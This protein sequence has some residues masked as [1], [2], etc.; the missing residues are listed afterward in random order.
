M[1]NNINPE[2]N[3]ELHFVNKHKHNW[4]VIFD[5]GCRNDSLFKNLECEVHYFEPELNFLNQLEKQLTNNKISKYNNF[6]LS[7][8]EGDFTYYERFQSFLNRKKTFPTINGT[9]K[10][11]SLKK[12]VNYLSD[13][14]IKNIDF[15]KID[16]EG[17]ELKVIKGF[18]DKIK[19]VN[20]IQ[21]EYG[22][23][24]LDADIKLLDVINHLNNNGFYKFSYLTGNGDL[25]EITDFS[26]HYQYSNIV[27]FNKKTN[28]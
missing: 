9:T 5:V 20:V 18:E 24:Y 13:L 15:L 17:F 7:D 27:C 3:G 21:F 23:T 19:I 8:I 11:L 6:G 14:E 4:Q 28:T 16:T 26:D 25:H 12:A 2:T 10:T 1:F 22:G